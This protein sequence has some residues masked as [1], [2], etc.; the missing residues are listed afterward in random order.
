VKRSK[1]PPRIRV[2][3]WTVHDA[4]RRLQQVWTLIEAESQRRLLAETTTSVP[5]APAIAVDLVHHEQ[6]NGGHTR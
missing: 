4:R 3:H 5:V 2:E 1:E 6:A